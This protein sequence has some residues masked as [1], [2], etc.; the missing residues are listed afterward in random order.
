MIVLNPGMV[1][2]VP[3]DKH[4]PAHTVRLL[5]HD[6]TREIY[7]RVLEAIDKGMQRSGREEK[8]DG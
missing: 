5:T 1:V 3:A 6:E 2:S 8:S 7:R 4:T